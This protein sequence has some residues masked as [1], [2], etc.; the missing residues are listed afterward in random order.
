MNSAKNCNEVMNISKNMLNS[1]IIYNFNP[2]PNAHLTQNL[3]TSKFCFQFS[4]LKIK[5]LSFK[6]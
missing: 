1:E 6:L 4:L 5:I 3:E 2:H